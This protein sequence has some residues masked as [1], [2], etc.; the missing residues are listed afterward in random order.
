M[1]HSR[2]SAHSRTGESGDGK[3]FVAA[4]RKRGAHPHLA[5]R[6]PL[7]S[8]S[9]AVGFCSDAPDVKQLAAAIGLHSHRMKWYGRSLL[10]GQHLQANQYLLSIGA[11]SGLGFSQ[12]LAHFSPAASPGLITVHDAVV[13]RQC[14]RRAT[15]VS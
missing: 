8:C 14:R 11:A 12:G 3:I 2:P 5:N 7:P 13:T 1:R 4:C 10:C 9:P 15:E 6:A